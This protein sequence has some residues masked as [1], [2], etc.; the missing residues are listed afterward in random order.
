MTAVVLAVA[1]AI[2]CASG[3]VR[4]MPGPAARVDRAMFWTGLA[5]IMSAFVLGAKP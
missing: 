4:P 2:L 5:L 1:G 3:T